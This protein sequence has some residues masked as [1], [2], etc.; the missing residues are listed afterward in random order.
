MKT[1]T[2]VP[3]LL[4]YLGGDDPIIGACV[5]ENS[6][7]RR[8]GNYPLE[9]FKNNNNNTNTA[10]E[11]TAKE[12]VASGSPSSYAFGLTRDGRT[13]GWDTESGESSHETR[14]CLPGKRISAIDLHS[15]NGKT[16]LF[17]GTEHGQCRALDVNLCQCV[18]VFKPHPPTSSLTSSNKS[19]SNTLGCIVTM[20]AREGILATGNSV[21]QTCIWDVTTGR[22]KRRWNSHNGQALTSIQFD[23]SEPHM[24]MRKIYTTA[25]DRSVRIWDIR[26]KNPQVVCFT[27]HRNTPVDVTVIDSIVYS[28]AATPTTPTTPPLAP[29]SNNNSK[30]KLGIS[31]S[32]TL[33]SLETLE[34]QLKR[35]RS[36]PLSSRSTMRD[37]VR[38]RLKRTPLRSSDIAAYKHDNADTFHPLQHSILAGMP[39]SSNGIRDIGELMLVHDLRSSAILRELNIVDSTSGLRTVRK[40]VMFCAPD[41]GRRT[42]VLAGENQ[43][44]TTKACCVSV[45]TGEML[46]DLAM[47]PTKASCTSL[48]CTKASSSASQIVMGWADGTFAA[49]SLDNVDA[50]HQN[51]AWRQQNLISAVTITEE[52]EEDDS[53]H[54]HN[55][56][57]REDT[58]ISLLNNIKKMRSKCESNATDWSWSEWQDILLSMVNQSRESTSVCMI[59]RSYLTSRE[60][61]LGTM[62]AASAGMIPEALS[63]MKMHVR[64]G[65]RTSD[66]LGASV[67]DLLPFQY[68]F[69]YGKSA[70]PKVAPLQNIGFEASIMI[71]EKCIQSI[72]ASGRIPRE[73]AMGG[74][75]RL[76]CRC[77]SLKRGLR[78]LAIARSR[79]LKPGRS[80]YEALLTALLKSGADRI[81][82]TK[83]IDEMIKYNITITASEFTLLTDANINEKKWIDASTWLQKMMEAGCL[84]QHAR[85]TA[86]RLLLARQ[87]DYTDTHSERSSKLNAKQLKRE[88]NKLI[89]FFVKIVRQCADLKFLLINVLLHVQ[90]AEDAYRLVLKLKKGETTPCN[91]DLNLLMDYAS[92]YKLPQPEVSTDLFL[93][94]SDILK[95]SVDGSIHA[96]YMRALLKSGRVDLALKHFTKLEKSGRDVAAVLPATVYNALLS[97][98]EASDDIIG[99]KNTWTK[100]IELGNFDAR[101]YELMM[102]HHIQHNSHDTYDIYDSPNSHDNRGGQEQTK[103]I[104]ALFE[105]FK[106]TKLIM[107][108]IIAS[109]AISIQTDFQPLQTLWSTIPA[110]MRN[111]KLC[112]TA[113]IKTSTEIALNVAARPFQNNSNVSATTL[114]WASQIF[115]NFQGGN[116]NEVQHDVQHDVQQDEETYF[117]QAVAGMINGLCTMREAVL[118]QS[119]L[120]SLESPPAQCYGCLIDC[121][122]TTGEHTRADKIVTELLVAHLPSLTSASSSLKK[123]R[124]RAMSA[125]IIREE[126]AKVQA[127]QQQLSTAANNSD[128]LENVITGLALGGRVGA[129]LRVARRCLARGFALPHKSLWEAI[130]QGAVSNAELGQQCWNAIKKS[131]FMPEATTWTAFIRSKGSDSA[132][133][134]SVLRKMRHVKVVAT[135][136]N[137]SA[138]LEACVAGGDT[139]GTTMMLKIMQTRSMQINSAVFCRMIQAAVREQ[140]STALEQ[141]IEILQFMRSSGARPD[142]PT[143]KA[144][145]HATAKLGDATTATLLMEQIN[146]TNTASGK[147]KKQNTSGMKSRSIEIDNDLCLSYVRSLAR[148]HELASAVDFVQNEMCTEGSSV[149]A[150]TAIWSTLLEGAARNQD[151]GRAEEIQEEIQRRGIMPNRIGRRALASVYARSNYIERALAAVATNK[152]ETQIEWPGLGA[153][154]Q[155]VHAI[156]RRLDSV[157][158]KVTTRIALEQTC[159]IF[160]SAF[161]GASSEQQRELVAIVCT[162]PCS[163]KSRLK[164]LHE[165]PRRGWGV[166]DPECIG[167]IEELDRYLIY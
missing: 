161:K 128:V 32:V 111:E 91:S 29:H 90:R 134:L 53:F 41:R 145:M 20:S 119:L 6:R 92:T 102:H 60:L 50:I 58:L 166:E 146:D 123:G 57:K 110:S 94:F 37:I 38:Q 48:G 74:F 157:K 73:E 81:E 5:E 65:I 63:L 133:A 69:G 147:R 139:E 109:F 34:H 117:T 116:G 93:H 44:G 108:P 56:T 121:L 144:M 85:K 26:L 42:I 54:H 66:K 88:E 27:S 126:E 61:E 55:T 89:S 22:L 107:T 163:M 19:S 99:L 153:T 124:P 7:R 52:K 87:K 18:T 76:L 80:V 154:K 164:I 59:N 72:K 64:T 118:A 67:M 62:A 125:K 135:T 75:I 148:G 15:K 104:M 156:G 150:G 12:E 39:K 159:M 46:Y 106:R 138:I 103:I 86:T 1:A 82:M 3:I 79:G 2:K 129:S 155:L 45:D 77:N 167:F 33:P 68:H 24:D 105:E 30:T 23:L 162:A 43:R 71:G 98:F 132:G 35:D 51:A 122:L 120:E 115:F 9:A 131:S 127:K 17:F 40:S 96:S 149:V 4:S 158:D 83:L 8:H 47:L 113:A 13:L 84:Q 136:E 143:L 97:A 70:V 21:G 114:R 165:P 78:E 14:A 28:C 142:L 112:V 160:R 140:T 101:S 95:N 137:C 10:A 151:F 141:G 100:M 152:D 11:I 16:L 49:W 36:F 31:A 25:K 130:L